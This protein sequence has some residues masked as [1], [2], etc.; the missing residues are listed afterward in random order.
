MQQKPHL[1]YLYRKHHRLRHH[2]QDRRHQDLQVVPWLRFGKIP[3]FFQ[4]LSLPC[5]VSTF[6]SV[7]A[8]PFCFLGE[9]NALTSLTLLPSILIQPKATTFFFS[10]KLRHGKAAYA[11]HSSLLFHISFNPTPDNNFKK[12]DIK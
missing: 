1:C 5:R 2:G 12:Q 9:L 3:Q 8:C 7:D 11:F 4:E 10:L 6:L